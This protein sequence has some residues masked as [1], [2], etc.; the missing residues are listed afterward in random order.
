MHYSRLR[1]GV[2]LAIFT[3]SLPVER[4]TLST[5]IEP[6]HYHALCQGI[7]LLQ[8]RHVAA[9]AVVLI[10]ASQF[11]LKNRPPFPRFPVIPYFSEPC[12]HLLTLHTEFL[13]TGLSKEDELTLTWD[14]S[15]SVIELRRSYTKRIVLLS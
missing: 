8:V 15:L 5:S 6:L 12:V 14:S 1:Q 13:V 10:M 4:F 2:V 11:R 3:K 7:I 9:Y